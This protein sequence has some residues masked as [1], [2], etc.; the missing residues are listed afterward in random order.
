MEFIKV[1]AYECCVVHQRSNYPG[2]E[3]TA[4]FSFPKDEDIRK[5]LPNRTSNCL[6][7]KI[8]FAPTIF[9]PINVAIQISL[10]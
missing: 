3:T 10:A 1:M 9:G 6:T 4:D 2:A 7:N 5:R 8:K